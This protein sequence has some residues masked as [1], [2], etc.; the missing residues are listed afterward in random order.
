[1][2]VLDKL[3]VS[4]GVRNNKPNQILAKE[5]AE[6]NDKEAIKELVENLNNKNKRIASDCIKVLYEIGYINPKLIAGYV[7]NFIDLL[8]HKNNRLVWGGMIALSTIAKYKA[9]K[10][11]ENFDN[12]KQ[13][14]ING[15]VITADK[16]IKTLSEIKANTE[17]EEKIMPFLLDT[18]KVCRS[19][20]FP[21]Y[22]EAIFEAVSNDYKNEYKKILEN[23]LPTLSKSQKKRV[24]KILKKI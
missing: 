24:E 6:K 16:G 20:S 12:I 21:Q 23:R 18:L 13:A 22:A 8:S 10:I 5:I 19:Q 7:N 3:S 15:S 9:D 14:I 1:M 4:L 11:Y 17:Y 2:S